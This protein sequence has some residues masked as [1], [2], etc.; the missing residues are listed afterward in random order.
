MKAILRRYLTK[1]PK[2]VQ[3]Q[4]LKIIW[5]CI[6]EYP[7]E[8]IE[9]AIK[10]WNEENENRL[11]EKNENWKYV[12][13]RTRKAYNCIRRKLNYCYTFK[14]YSELW[15]PSTNNSSE[16]INSHL[17]TK[18]WIHRWLWKNNSDKF[19]GYYLYYS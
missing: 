12:H 18:K 7:K 9:L 8:D 13:T 2:L 6:W 17:K 15:I 4:K 16:W 10:V 5:S 11:N 19:I 1:K 3:N 14:E